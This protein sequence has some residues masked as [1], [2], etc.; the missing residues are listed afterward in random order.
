MSDVPSKQLSRLYEHKEG[1]HHEKSAAEELEERLKE[2]QKLKSDSFQRRQAGRGLD[3][4]GPWYEVITHTFSY[5]RWD[6][7]LLP[8][9]SNFQEPSKCDCYSIHLTLGKVEAEDSWCIR[10]KG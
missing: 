5:L 7:Y 8:N 6:S 9:S 1:D 4:Q 3:T 2:Y 10:R